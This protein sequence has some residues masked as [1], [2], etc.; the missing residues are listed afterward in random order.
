[1]A[2]KITEMTATT[3]ADADALDVIE[4]VDVST[5][6]NKK[7]TLAQLASYVI[8]LIKNGS[9]KFSS[10]FGLGF[11]SAVHRTIAGGVISVGDTQYIVVDT[12]GAAASDNLD[13]INISS[14]SFGDVI[15]LQAEDSARSIV[16]K[17]GTGNILCGADITLDNA[18]DKLLLI[19][20]DT[21]DW[22]VLSFYNNGA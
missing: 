5:S 17:N 4:V 18:D 12:E 2:G 22:C 10:G 8:T 15:V 11:G 13:T 20:S 16:V 6:L 19:L 9:T 1:M 21:G 14:C 7:M 3:T